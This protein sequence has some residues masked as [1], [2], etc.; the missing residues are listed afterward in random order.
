M[1]EAK[2]EKITRSEALL[3]GPP[4]LL[5]CGFPKSAQSKFNALIATAGLG[6]IPRVWATK[7][8]S[9]EIVSELLNLPDH[10]GLGASSD[11]P[12][13][14]IVSG[15]QEKQLHI[16]MALCRKTRM[17]QALWA[18]LTPTSEKWTL[19]ALLSELQS[20]KKVMQRRR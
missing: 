3:Y 12:R 14:V 17:P 2:F 18:V 7:D 9:T 10:T 13:A 16:L 19:Q 20:E 5:L 8:H 6:G 15:I 1:A 4:K 11:L